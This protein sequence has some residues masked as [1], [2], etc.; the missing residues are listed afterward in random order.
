LPLGFGNQPAEARSGLAAACG[1]S[2][3]LA[4]DAGLIPD[5]VHNPGKSI[6]DV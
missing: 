4:Y 6:S 5:C 1:A 3:G 2:G